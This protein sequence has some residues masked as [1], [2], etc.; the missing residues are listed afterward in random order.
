MRNKEWH[1]G[2]N[3]PFLGNNIQGNEDASPIFS[4]SGEC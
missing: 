4:T 3:N 2:N 1:L